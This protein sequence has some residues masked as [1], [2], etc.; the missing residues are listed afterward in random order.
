MDTINKAIIFDRDGVINYLI[1]RP[2]DNFDKTLGWYSPLTLKDFSF[3]DGIL[4]QIELFKKK[5]YLII[6]IKNEPSIGREL[7]IE[8]FLKIDRF[9]RQTIKPAEIY[10]CPHRTKDNCGC[11]KPKPGLFLQ[12]I[13]DFNLDINESICIG[14]SPS[15]TT[16]ARA[17]GFKQAFEVES[18]RRGENKNG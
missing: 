9:V 18:C 15:D 12:A 16:A 14:D 8:E 10:Y 1:F 6:I 17:A 7:S 4:E 13:K 2:K 11:K 3:V 5:G